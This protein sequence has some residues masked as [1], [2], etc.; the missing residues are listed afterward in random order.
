MVDGSAG[1]SLSDFDGNASRIQDLGAFSRNTASG[2]GL[3]VRSF[4][5]SL[6]VAQ[7]TQLFQ[8]AWN[9][10]RVFT[11]DHLRAGRGN[12][13]GLYNVVKQETDAGR[14]VILALTRATNVGHAILAYGVKDVSD[15]ESQILLY[16]NNYPLEERYLTLKKDASGTFMNWSY[17]MRQNVVWGSEGANGATTSIG[18][19]PYSVIKEIWRTKGHLAENENVVS[20]NS[21]SLA[22][23]EGDSTSPIATVTGGELT[24]HNSD[25][26]I[27]EELREEG[28]GD[29]IFLSMPV[30]VYTFNNLDMSVDE[31]E[32]SMVDQNL[33]STVS[34]TANSVTLAV[35][36]SCNLNATY[37]DASKD[38]TYSVTL[39]SSFGYGDDS[40]V[41]TGKGSGETLEVSQS[42]G[43]I[44]IS[45][46][47]IISVSID[48]NEIH[49]YTIDSSAGEGGTITPEGGNIITE[50]GSIS[51]TIQPQS[52]YEIGDVLVDGKS[53]GAVTAY[54]FSNVSEDHDIKAVFSKKAVPSGGASSG[55]GNNNGSDNKGSGQ[56][57]NGKASK[58]QNIISAQNLTLTSSSK[59]K[60]ISLGAASKGNTKLSYSSNNSSVKVTADGRV[61]IP[62]N[63]VGEAIITINAAETSQYTAA[64]KKVTVTIN[65]TGTTLKKLKKNGSGKMTVTWK[66]NK[67]VTGYQISYSMYSNFSNEKIKTVKKNKTVKS[68]LKKLKKKKKYYVRIRTYKMVGGRKYYSAW[69]KVKTVKID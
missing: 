52:G 47:Q 44:N 56:K 21:K 51:Y 55:S 20:A 31:F 17:T 25:I 15:T 26:H 43:T 22:I 46:C 12:L 40:V 49:Y 63:Y 48:G 61:T 57:G 45:N 4:I 58:Q 14:P 3:D 36:D 28:A 35:D 54:T 37:I 2:L 18:Y 19:I 30:D 7:K 13:N 41:V 69:S 6:Q 29:Q 16:D 62:K 67:K 42:H 53:V 32:V 50:G 9:S 39:S 65:P 1:V 33:G 5:E 10:H 34:T 60:S 24:T 66:R 64:S 8:E 11:K 38:D 23:Y 68:V 27:I 59:T